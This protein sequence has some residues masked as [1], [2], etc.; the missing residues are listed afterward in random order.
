MVARKECQGAEASIILA[1]F[2][3]DRV[4]VGA[5]PEVSCGFRAIE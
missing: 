3:R 2:T 1:F 5:I 4:L